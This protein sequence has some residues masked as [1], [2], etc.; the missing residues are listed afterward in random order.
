[1]Q[2]IPILSYYKVKTSLTQHELTQFVQLKSIHLLLMCFDY[3]T[4]NYKDHFFASSWFMHSEL[5][6]FW[7]V[8]THIRSISYWWICGIKDNGLKWQNAILSIWALQSQLL[9]MLLPMY[10][11][12]YYNSLLTLII[13]CL[14]LLNYLLPNEFINSTYGFVNEYSYFTYNATRNMG[15]Y[16]KYDSCNVLTS[17]I[18]KA[19]ILVYT[20]T[21]THTHTHMYITRLYLTNVI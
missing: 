16:S 2:R 3:W 11:D 4:I 1:M 15:L 10:M 9:A 12:S 8:V 20:H 18:P 7:L 13:L 17:F 6:Q 5:D 14:D 19:N 21:H